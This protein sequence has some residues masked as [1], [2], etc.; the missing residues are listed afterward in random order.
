MGRPRKPDAMT[1]AVQVRT[2]RARRGVTSTVELTADT[3]ER[4][5][6]IRDRDG[7]RSNAEVVRRLVLEASG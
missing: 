5:A 4:L 2:S 1:P 3:A 6:A 7:D